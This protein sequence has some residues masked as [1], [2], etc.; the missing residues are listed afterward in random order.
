ML[1][2]TRRP[3]HTEHLHLRQSG[4]DRHRRT[5]DI[6]YNVR[7]PGQKNGL[8]NGITHRPSLRPVEQRPA[9]GP[10]PDGAGVAV[11]AGPE[12]GLARADRSGATGMRKASTAAGPR[13]RGQKGALPASDADARARG[14][15]V[16]PRD[17]N[18][19]AASYCSHQPR[20]T[21][22]ADGVALPYGH[23]V[24]PRRERSGKHC[25]HGAIET[26]PWRTSASAPLSTTL[27]MRVAC[28]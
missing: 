20:A 17:R 1:T 9:T 13:G 23:A 2:S 6:P 16:L 21:V 14:E 4:D 12:G 24:G 22:T 5:D 7:S 18:D 10:W 26:V 19:P 11:P 28:N 25:L 27:W 15:P 3:R 8:P